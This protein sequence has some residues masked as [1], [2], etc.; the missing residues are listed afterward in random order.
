MTSWAARDLLQPPAKGQIAQ[1]PT[2]GGSLF[3]TAERRKI[4]IG[5]SSVGDKPASQPPTID[6]EANTVSDDGSLCVALDIDSA[7]GFA[8]SLAVAREGLHWKA[9]RSQVSNLLKLPPSG[10][11]SGAVVCDKW[12]ASALATASPSR[13][14]SSTWPPCRF[15]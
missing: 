11:D 4:F 3:P 15:L 14:P 9:H 6:L 2:A 8:S 7:G 5:L 1:H 12:P 10:P 13:P